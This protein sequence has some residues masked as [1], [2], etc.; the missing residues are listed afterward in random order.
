MFSTREQGGGI[1]KGELEDSGVRERKISTNE[2]RWKG[3]NH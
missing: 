2:K 1:K 3:I